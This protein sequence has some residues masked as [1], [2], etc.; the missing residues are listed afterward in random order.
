M[1]KAPKALGVTAAGLYHLEVEKI[2]VG[3]EKNTTTQMIGMHHRIN[4]VVTI[5]VGRLINDRMDLINSRGI[6]ICVP[7]GDTRQV[8]VG[9]TL[10]MP[11]VFRIMVN[12]E[13][14]ETQI[15]DVHL[16]IRTD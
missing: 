16:I 15:Q 12:L 10:R 7:N 8:S 2:E 1:I 4:V 11:L 3:V 5:I 14:G 13:L 9:L 6:V